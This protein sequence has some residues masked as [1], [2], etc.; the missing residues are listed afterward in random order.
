M[1]SVNM[2]I[3]Y[4]AEI[5]RKQALK[6]KARH[7]YESARGTAH[8]A[9]LTRAKKQTSQKIKQI[10]RA[11]KQSQ[12]KINDLKR[13]RANALIL[14]LEKYIAYNHLTEVPGIGTKLRDTLLRR[15]FVSRLSDLQRSFVVTGIGE[16]RQRDI[17]YW[18]WLYEQRKPEMLVQDFPGKKNVLSEYDPNLK[19]L[20]DDNH[21]L[22]S[23]KTKLEIRNEIAISY[24]KKL[25]Q[26][27][28]T[29]FKNALLLPGSDHPLL[30][31]YCIGLFPEW[32]PVP[33][34]FKVLIAEGE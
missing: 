2:V 5:K 15:V 33:D 20:A 31:E 21:K 16:A 24:I 23:D 1:G 18:I 7:D 11:I 10:D 8:L 6:R 4:I 30:D 22:K 13:Q 32:E 26:V 34:W 12:A 3:D 28:V 9:F 14:A 25:E 17:N 29:D 27:T 19:T